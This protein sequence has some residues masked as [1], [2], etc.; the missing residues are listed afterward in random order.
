MEEKD[1]KLSGKLAVGAQLST[2]GGVTTRL[3]LEIKRGGQQSRFGR[4]EAAALPELP[5][6]IKTTPQ[7]CTHQRQ[8][9]PAKPSKTAST[10]TQICELLSA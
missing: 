2:Q 10:A 3:R 8:L 5:G 6:I 4:A 1:V 9:P 7:S